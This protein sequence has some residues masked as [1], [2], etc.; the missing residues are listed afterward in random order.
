MKEIYCINLIESK[1]RYEE[2]SKLFQELKLDSPIFRFDAVRGS[3]VQGMD[4]DLTAGHK[5]CLLSHMCLWFHIGQKPG[6][7]FYLILEDDLQLDDGISTESFKKE[8]EDF[9][10][11]I[12]KNVGMVHLSRDINKMFIKNKRISKYK[13][14]YKVLGDFQ[15]HE[16]K[17]CSPLN[18]WSTETGAILFRPR[19]A[20]RLF[21]YAKWSLKNDKRI[22]WRNNVDLLV[23]RF[24]LAHIGGAMVKVFQQNVI[25]SDLKVINK[26][27]PIQDRPPLFY[28]Q[29]LFDDTPQMLTP[30][31]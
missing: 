6:N 9:V 23:T 7:D 1:H 5:G 25:K 31:E 3:R 2:M 29:K 8:L 15:G 19:Y 11:G 30:W 17:K 26:E 20:R 28:E 22:P 14:R 24:P 18:P 13:P 12:P 16:L 21:K 10:A 27:E 4:A